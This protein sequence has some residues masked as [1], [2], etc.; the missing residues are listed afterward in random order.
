MRTH[1][2]SSL[3]APRLGA[4]LAMTVIAWGCG[5]DKQTAPSLIGPSGHALSL[6]LLA[7][8]DI[9]PRDGA[10]I[11]VI[12][13]SARDAQGQP[14]GGQRLFMSATTGTLSVGE[15]VTGSNGEATVDFTAPPL[16]QN[17]N[18]A[19]IGAIPFGSNFDNSMT[20]TVSI[21][22]SGPPIPL[23]SFTFTPAAPTVGAAVAFDASG[24]LLGGGGCDAACTYSWS[25]S[26][27]DT[28]IGQTVTH[29]FQTPGL[30]SIT[31]TVTSLSGGT[32][33]TVTRTLTVVEPGLP[34]ATF[35][36][37]PTSPRVNQV[38]Q[39]DAGGS[40]VGAGATIVEYSWVWGDG[41]ANTV[42]ASPQTQHT[43]TAV[44]TYVVRLTTRDSLNRTA[45][46]TT[47]LPI[48]P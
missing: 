35:T 30:Q 8:P 42:T 6:T 26:D 34:T 41:T 22:L 2:L 1:I 15:V 21:A 32:S 27:G 48:A 40:T 11:S 45:T 20:R 38:V 43:F 7:T 18:A 29:S 17:V 47:N 37:S 28:A 25:F 39:F 12:R 14:V 9:L 36:V 31:L 23:A 24:S 46:I 19:V 16:N 10:S 33:A 4:I 5:L 13:V 44:A 3:A